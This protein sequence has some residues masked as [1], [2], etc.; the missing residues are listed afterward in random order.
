MMKNYIKTI[1]LIALGSLVLTAC[2]DAQPL[3]TVGTLDIEKYTGKWYEIARFPNRFEKGLK[4]V[5][6]T[7]T[8]KENGK[9]EVLNQG[10]KIDNPSKIEQSKGSAWIP[11]ATYPGQL[12]VSF[13][14]PFAGDYYV[15]ELGDTY[16]YSLVGSPDR[17]YLW[18]LSRTPS[19]PENTIQQLKQIAEDNGFDP[20]QLELI[21]QNCQ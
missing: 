18:I 8:L 7:Y 11:D 5:T 4:C 14:W 2:K 9:I 21:E 13:F 1:L 10:V 19:L 16:Q 20:S 15:I 6:A 3:K 17:D 12:K